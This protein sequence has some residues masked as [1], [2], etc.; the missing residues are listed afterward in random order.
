MAA[1]KRYLVTKLSYI[2]VHLVQP[3]EIVEYDGEPG[4]AL[5]EVDAKGAPVTAAGKKALAE[6]TATPEPAG[7]E[8]DLT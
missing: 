4:S 7:E 3:G 5:I 2:G 6:F 8:A 1:K